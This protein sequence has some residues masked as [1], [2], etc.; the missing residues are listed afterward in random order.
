VKSIVG[1]LTL[2]KLYAV[3]MQ[4]FNEFVTSHPDLQVYLPL[5]SSYNISV[6]CI[7]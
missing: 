5:L 1:S 2:T 7:N 4:R 3:G 6:A